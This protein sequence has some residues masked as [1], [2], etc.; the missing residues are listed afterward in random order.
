[1]NVNVFGKRHQILVNQTSAFLSVT[2]LHIEYLLIQP[3]E[4]ICD[5]NVLTWACDMSN[6]IIRD[7]SLMFL[8][9]K[10]QKY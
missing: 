3:I 9:D 10:K 6:M 2:S 4:S 5:V 7:L 8:L 1:M